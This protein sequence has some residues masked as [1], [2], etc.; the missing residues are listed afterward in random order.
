M[1]VNL[2]TMLDAKLKE[3]LEAKLKEMLE[4]KLKEMTNAPILYTP[5]SVCK[6]ECNQNQLAKSI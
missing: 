2:E 1:E 3:M 4:A 5:K 6:S